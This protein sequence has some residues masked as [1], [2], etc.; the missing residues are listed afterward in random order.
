MTVVLPRCSGSGN[1]L[2]VETR[3]SCSWRG[4][5]R[6][7]AT[8]PVTLGRYWP[9][10]QNACSESGGT[11]GSAVVRA[12]RRKL[13]VGIAFSAMLT[14]KKS[15]VRIKDSIETVSSPADSDRNP[16][17]P[18]PR[19]TTKFTPLRRKNQHGYC[20]SA[21]NPALSYLSQDFQAVFKV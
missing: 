20:I 21:S 9:Y 5:I 10:L 12:Q 19:P 2:G 8:A 14:E 11:A 13:Y 6:A 1:G 18:K 17:P 4:C 16:K 7:V 3:C 15:K